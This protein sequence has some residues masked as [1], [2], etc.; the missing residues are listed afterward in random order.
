MKCHLLNAYIHIT[1]FMPDS[2]LHSPQLLNTYKLA[3]CKSTS[4][5]TFNTAYMHNSVWKLKRYNEVK[6]EAK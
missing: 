6:L 5:V 3:L 4:R 2:H 1:Y